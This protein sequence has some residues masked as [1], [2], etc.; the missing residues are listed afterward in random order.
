[1]KLL[2]SWPAVVPANTARAHVIDPIPRIY[3][4]DYDLSPMAEIDDDIVLLEWDIAVDRTSLEVFVERAKAKPDTVIVAPYRLYETTVRSHRLKQPVWCHR[5]SDGSH[6]AT[7]ERWCSAFGFGLIYFP[8]SVV[9]A[10][11]A[12]WQGHFSDGSFSGWH[13]NKV[14]DRVEIIW[15]APA[16]HLH[17]TVSDLGF[18]LEEREPPKRIPVSS[19]TADEDESAAKRSTSDI[20]ALLRERAGYKRAGRFDRAAAVDEQ[21]A[22]RGYQ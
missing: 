9:E 11:R 7:G 1:M 21:L 8:R 15:D 10:F 22:L 12:D 3:L 14:S 2:R 16:T 13:K 19:S 18:E 17:Y 6:V 4:D 5:R 20:S